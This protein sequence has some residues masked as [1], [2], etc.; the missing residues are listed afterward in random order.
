MATL[1]ARLAPAHGVRLAVRI[2]IHTGLVG[3]GAVGGG[4][5]HDLLAVGAPPNLAARLQGPA[6][7]DTVGLRE[8]TSGRV[9]GDFTGQERG[10][11]ALKGFD[12]PMRVYRVVGTSATQSRLDVAGATGLTPLV[13]REEGGGQVV[14]LS[15]EAG[16][17]KPRLGQGLTA[18]VVEEGAPRLPVRGAPSHTHSAFYPVIAHLQRRLRWHRHASPEARLATREQA[19]QTAGL[20]LEAGVPLVAALLSLPV[21]AH[22]PPLRRRPPRQKPPPQKMLVAWLLAEAAQ[23]PVLA[24]WE[25]VHWADPCT[26]ELLGLLLDQ[27]PTA[28]LL[29]VLTCRPAFQPPWA[30]R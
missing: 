20:P 2:G 13:G 29:M 12:T 14:L 11:Q 28:R 1:H 3:G 22:Y 24:V 16:L 15:G 27:A 10:T 7:P 21:P 25:D 26:L 30:P 18:R 5:R 8:A 9:Q 19:L 6:A 4:D 17:G 23:P